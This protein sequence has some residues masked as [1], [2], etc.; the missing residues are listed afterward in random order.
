MVISVLYLPVKHFSYE[1]TEVD[2]SKVIIYKN[3]GTKSTLYKACYHIFFISL[4]CANSV[5]D[6][7]LFPMARFV[8][9][10]SVRILDNIL[11]D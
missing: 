3:K 9:D 8:F 2:H 7:I 10:I 4:K 1:R 6:E 11:S 5:S